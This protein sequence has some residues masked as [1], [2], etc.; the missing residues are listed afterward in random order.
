MDAAEITVR[1]LQYAAGLTGAGGLAALLWAGETPGR[2]SRAFLAVCCGL[3]AAGAL[4]NGLVFSHAVLGSWDE[5][6]SADG[7]DF[8]LTTFD[9]A[10][11]FLARAV[12]AGLALAAL[13]TLRGKPAAWIALALLAGA[14]ASF[15]WTGHAASGEGWEGGLHKAATISHIIAAAV[16]LGALGLFLSRLFAA[17]AGNREYRQR[18]ARLLSRFSGIGSAAVAALVI[19][20]GANTVL[21][22][23]PDRVMAMLETPY[24]GWLAV[25]LALFAG[26]LGLAALNRFMLAPALAQQLTGQAAGRIRLAVLA[27]TCLGAGVVACVAVLGITSPHA[28]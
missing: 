7:A 28:G 18:T 27:E 9:P 10:L 17:Q 8:V 2:A 11:G 4:A 22:A 26:M 25:K 19:T 12:L 16:W 5:V 15:A 6:F 3:L 20:G 21:V 1:T 13:L 14:L 24:G 23:G